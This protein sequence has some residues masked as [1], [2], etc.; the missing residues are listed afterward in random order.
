M[1]EGAAEGCDVEDDDGRARGRMREEEVYH[2]L[3]GEDDGMQFVIVI[4]A[5]VIGRRRY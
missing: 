2:L 5:I 4:I 3:L 1:V